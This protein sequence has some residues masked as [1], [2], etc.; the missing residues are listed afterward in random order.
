MQT[1]I[2]QYTLGPDA[3]LLLPFGTSLLDIQT[4]GEHVLVFV[5]EPDHSLNFKYAFVLLQD[6]DLTLGPNDKYLRTIYIEGLGYRHVYQLEGH[7]S[8]IVDHIKTEFARF[9]IEPQFK[10]QGVIQTDLGSY[11][12]VSDEYKIGDEPIGKGFYV[13][14]YRHCDLNSEGN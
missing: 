2:K 8:Q 10:P 11:N 7:M 5:E 1:R 14:L 12:I 3:T 4:Q 9:E 6:S 13:F